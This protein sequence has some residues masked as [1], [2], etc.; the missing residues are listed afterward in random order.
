MT[1]TL[2]LSVHPEPKS[3][4]ATWAAATLAAARRQGHKVLVSDLYE[5]GFDPAD[6]GSLYTAPFARFDPLKAQE[7]ATMSRS[8]PLDVAR[9]AGKLIDA[10]LVVMHF[11]VWWFAPPAMLKGW[12]DRVLVH[13][14]LHDVDHRFDR[15]RLR[16]KRALI[17]ATSGATAVEAGPSGLE[18]DVRLALWPLYMTLRYLGIGVYEPM[19][20]HG[21][22]GY[23]EGE[24]KA[25][26]DDRLT[27]VLRA[28]NEVLA[29]LPDRPLL[30]FNA[31]GDFDAE[32]RLRP[33]APVHWPFTTLPEDAPAR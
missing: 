30:T 9:E 3:F 29:T 13:G 10:D 31:D 24:D 5:L 16:G 17:C 32:G 26:L 8:L 1:T 2:V 22:H 25:E 4:T 23:H 33:G 15:G 6:R 14:L 12:L 21:V 19:I 27:R 20:L 28:Q 18:G 11:P 7:E